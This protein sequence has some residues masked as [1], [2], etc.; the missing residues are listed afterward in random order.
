MGTHLK[1]EWEKISEQEEK[2]VFWFATYRARVM[3][4]WLVRTFDLSKQYAGAATFD[5][6]IS[7]S[8]SMVFVPDG[9]HRWSLKDDPEIAAK[10]I[11]FLKLRNRTLMCLQAEGIKVVGDI[12]KLPERELF[13]IPN[14]GKT[15][16]N[17]LKAA[18]AQHN[19]FLEIRNY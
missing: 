8:E 11:G 16:L 7:K 12:L 15:S 2:G 18:L 14:F 9:T 3:G 1:F 13:K 17:D 6:A 19:L 10:P 5:L 4:G